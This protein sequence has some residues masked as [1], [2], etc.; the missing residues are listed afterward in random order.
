MKSLSLSLSYTHVY[1]SSEIKFALF[2]NLKVSLEHW[3]S[4]TQTWKILLECQWIKLEVKNQRQRQWEKK[5]YKPYPV[6]S[7]NLRVA[8]YQFI[9]NSCCCCCVASV[10]SDSVRPR[11][12]QP[13]QGSPVPGILQART[14]E[15][16]AISFSNAWKW[17]VKVKSL[18]RVRLFASPWTAA[19]QAPPSMGF[20]RQEYWSVVPLPSPS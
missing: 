14:L 1:T 17:K 18:S 3:F 5:D 9:L 7:I 2:L 19:H 6:S 15:W 20:S 12:R 8:I 10:V 13:N 11:R 16:V 4:E